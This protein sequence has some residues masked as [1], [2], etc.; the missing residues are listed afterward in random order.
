MSEEARHALASGEVRSR[1]R[2]R[3]R[4]IRILAALS[5][6][7]TRRKHE[8]RSQG[9]S[10]LMVFQA[11][12]K[13]SGK[14]ANASIRNLGRLTPMGGGGLSPFG[15][16]TLVLRVPPCEYSEHPCEYSEY[17]GGGLSPFGRSARRDACTDSLRC[18]PPVFNTG[19]GTALVL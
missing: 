15:R 18:R 13:K 8:L 19:F 6:P 1:C 9:V 7:N 17:P 3:A 11:F 14:M 4:A 5:G 16:L 12:G 10:R 2:G